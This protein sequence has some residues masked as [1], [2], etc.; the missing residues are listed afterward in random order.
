MEQLTLPPELA[1]ALVEAQ[2]AAKAVEKTGWND[3]KG[4]PFATSEALLEEGRRALGAA[5][6]AAFATEPAFVEE[7]TEGPEGKRDLVSWCDMALHVVHRSGVGV[8]F[9]IRH[10]V[11]FTLKGPD[12]A[13]PFGVAR[14]RALGLFV[15]DLLLLPAFG[16]D[17]PEGKPEGRAADRKAPRGEPTEARRV[18]EESRRHQERTEARTGKVD[19]QA[20]L[21]RLWGAL[22]KACGNNQE[23]AKG[24]WGRNKLPN[25]KTGLKGM[26]P[27]AAVVVLADARALV[28]RV[29]ANQM[30][31]D[32][33]EQIDTRGT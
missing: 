9:K 2:I 22:V 5:G 13:K 18:M 27:A 33:N 7:W 3:D 14:T 10:P 16:D 8:T 11:V 20:E 23:Y 17:Q 12:V 26:E 24:W 1:A 4:Y 21:D 15:R 25:P 29:A 19:Q 28:E 32:P 6:L 30:T 31:K